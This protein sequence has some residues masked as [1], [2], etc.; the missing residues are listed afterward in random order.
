MLLFVGRPFK[1]RLTN[2]IEIFNEFI[3]LLIGY[4]VCVLTGFNM[5]SKTRVWIGL[6]IIFLVVLLIKLHII[7]WL[8]GFG[9]KL[10]TKYKQRK[11]R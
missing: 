10:R 5:N 7:R 8:V 2:Y 4:H 6:S 11:Q 9:L 3:V 1:E